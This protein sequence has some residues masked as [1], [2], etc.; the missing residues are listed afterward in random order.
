MPRNMK[1][2][3]VHCT[4]T[5]QKTSI[6]AIQSYWQKQLGW[7]MPGYHF[8]IKPDGEI[9]QLLPIEQVSNGVQGFNSETINISYIG[10][11][12]ENNV[13]IDNRTP[14]Q[15]A[16]LLKKLK[17]LKIKFP[18]AKIQ[19]HRDFPKVKKACPSFDALKEYKDL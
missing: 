19:G 17:E 12:D 9:V 13:P 10:G 16:S 7:K 3:A 11:V 4:A 6:S 8:I 14:A 5:S 1:Y 18:L 2:I 15:K